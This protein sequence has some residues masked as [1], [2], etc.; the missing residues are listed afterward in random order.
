MPCIPIASFVARITKIKYNDTVFFCKVF[1]IGI[2]Y[3]IFYIL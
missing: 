3:F 2:I 1:Q